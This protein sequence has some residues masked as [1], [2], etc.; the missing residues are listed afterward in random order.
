MFPFCEIN[1]ERDFKK[2]TR[3][4]FSIKT[5]KLFSKNK[6]DSR[7]IRFGQAYYKGN[8]TKSYETFQKVRNTIEQ[9]YFT[10]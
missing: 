1:S 3:I 7:K 4:L 10:S 6:E 8:I 2:K 5:R 9:C